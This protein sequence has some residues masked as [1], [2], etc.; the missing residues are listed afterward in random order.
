MAEN[1]PLHH[2]KEIMMARESAIHAQDTSFLS[3]Q[4]DGFAIYQLKYSDEVTDIRFMT[5]NI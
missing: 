1:K 4:G 2:I 5:W 3:M